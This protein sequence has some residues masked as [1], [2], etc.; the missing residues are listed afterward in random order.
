MQPACG[1]C[2]VS[3]AHRTAKGKR[4]RGERA[5]EFAEARDD[6]GLLVRDRARPH[7]LPRAASALHRAQRA[8]RQPPA[9]AKAL[10]TSL[11][12]MVKASRKALAASP[13]SA[14]GIAER[15]WADRRAHQPNDQTTKPL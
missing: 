12:P 10:A 14:P 6:A 3:P 13:V 11:A 4:D 9:L 15:A 8:C 2:C 1:E 7:C 5:E